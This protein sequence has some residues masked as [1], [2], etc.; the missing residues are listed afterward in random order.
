M[1]TTG[2]HQPA[3]RPGLAARRAAPRPAPLS[4][5]RLGGTDRLAIAALAS[6][7]IWLAVW[8]ALV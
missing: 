3:R 4:L 6:L 1:S 8:W 5:L 2:Q 7:L